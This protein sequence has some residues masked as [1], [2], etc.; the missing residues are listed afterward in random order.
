MP[1]SAKKPCHAPGGCPNV[2]DSRYCAEHQHL[3]TVERERRDAIRG[4]AHSRGY[5]RRHQAI[6]KQ[7]LRRDPLCRI[8]HHCR[9]LAAS[10]EADHIIPISKGGPRYA[11]SNL[12]GA[13][14]ACHS[15][16]TAT[17][18][19]TFTETARRYR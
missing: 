7:V 10:T 14:H 3:A 8:A 17:Q 9:G 19:S 1:L 6:R 4:T 2:S 5:D 18:D 11:L 16:K 15:W 13:C 12:Q